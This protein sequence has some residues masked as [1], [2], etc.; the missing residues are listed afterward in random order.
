MM[1]VYSFISVEYCCAKTET[2]LQPR[3]T[4]QEDCLMQSVHLSFTINLPK[5]LPSTNLNQSNQIKK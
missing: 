2:E 4:Y 3:K 1:A 5:F